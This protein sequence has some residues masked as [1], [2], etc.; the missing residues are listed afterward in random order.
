MDTL[1]KEKKSEKKTK[2]ENPPTYL[3]K[4]L[5]AGRPQEEALDSRREASCGVIDLN[6][7][8][9]NKLFQ[10]FFFI[11]KL[12]VWGNIYNMCLKYM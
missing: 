11:P 2:Q 9:L 1:L 10:S 3:I 6:S 12:K 8:S 4:A 5:T 7:K